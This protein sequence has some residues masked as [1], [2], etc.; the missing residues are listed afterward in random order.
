MKNIEIKARTTNHVY[1]RN[2]LSRLGASFKGTDRQRDTYFNT[3]NGR[4]KLRH[5]NIE[6][7]LV[8]YSRSDQAG[9]KRSNYHLYQCKDPDNLRKCLTQSLGILID[10]NK[11]RE[12][13]FLENVKIH[14]DTVDDLGTFVEIEARDETDLVSDEKLLQQCQSLMLDFGIKDSD[15]IENSYSDMLYNKN[16]EDKK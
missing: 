8:S 13:Y 16:L 5:G 4:L 14:L 3:P 10:V 7:T 12:I 11:S 2:I 15:L 6:T 9:P 1:I